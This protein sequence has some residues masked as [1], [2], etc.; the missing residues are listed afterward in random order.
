[1]HAVIIRSGSV[2]TPWVEDLRANGLNEPP[3]L[4]PPRMAKILLCA[5]WPYTSG[6]RHLGHAASTFIPAD[7]FARYHRMKG[8]EAL[9][10]GG[11]HMHGAP[12][13]VPAEQEGA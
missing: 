1:M 8:D 10:R 3:F 7:I 6:P 13:I 11:G 5:A 4:D 9:M 12:T 2:P